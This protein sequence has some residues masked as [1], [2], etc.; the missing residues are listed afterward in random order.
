[1]NVP[2]FIARKVAASGQRSFSRLIIRIAIVAVALSTS[3]MIV[4]TALIAGFK[5][6]IS[7]KIFGFWGHIH[8]TE[9]DVN[10]TL[11]DVFPIEKEQEFYPSLDTMGPVEYWKPFSLLGME[12]PSTMMNRKTHGGVRHIQVFGLMPGIIETKNAIE[13]IILKGIS[14]DFDW[15]FLDKYLQEGERLDLSDTTASDGI[16]ISRQTADRLDLKTGDRFIVYFVESNQQLRRAF[17]IQGIYK[18]GLEEYDLKFALV[19]IRKIQQMLNWE[20]NQVAGFEVFV[21]DIRDLQVLSEYIYVEK[22]PRE[23]YAET[24]RDKFPSIFEWLTLQDINEQVILALMLIVGIINMVTALLILILER[25]NMIGILKAVGQRNWGIRQIFLYYG[26]FILG[27]GLFWGNLIGIGLCLL[28]KHFKII[29]LSEANYYLSVAPV[30]LNPLTVLGLN[31]LTTVVTLVFLLLPSYL[32]SRIRPV[33][34]IRF[35]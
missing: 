15:A 26:M 32:V 12:F 28:Q 20:E 21:D 2:F 23:M 4:A 11:L 24:I 35:K 18:T 13:G 27:L 30:E 8:I 10:R 33:Q 1:M 16:L 19:D 25:T 29:T 34:A 6:E 3:V 17:R 22:L 5:H 9:A 14:E 31:V 7:E